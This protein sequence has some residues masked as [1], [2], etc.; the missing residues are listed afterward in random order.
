MQHIFC[1]CRTLC[2]TRYTLIMPKSE[3]EVRKSIKA[4]EK[5]LPES[6]RN[7]NVKNDVEGAIAR[8]SRPLGVKPEKRPPAG[9]YIEKQT[10]SHNTEDTSG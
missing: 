5:T 3:D 6:E 7:P 10:H 2:E 8:A 4:Y 1:D 9:S